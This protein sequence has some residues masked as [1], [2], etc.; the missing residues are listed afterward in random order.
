MQYILDYDNYIGQNHR[1]QGLVVFEHLSGEYKLTEAWRQNYEFDVDQLWAGPNESKNIDGI[2]REKARTGF[3]YRL[4][5]YNSNCYIID[6]NFV[7]YG[8]L[9][10]HSVTLWIILLFL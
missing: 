6:Y 10:I 1:I 2:E 4:S 9:V 7:Y 5:F 3:V 8:S